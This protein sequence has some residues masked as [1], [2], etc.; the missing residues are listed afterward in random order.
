MALLLW[1]TG[2]GEPQLSFNLA[3]HAGTLLA[4]IIY[5]R[6]T[7]LRLLAAA[8][9]MVVERKVG[10]DRDRV[11]VSYL[12]VATL[13]AL[14]L[15]AFAGESA[16]MMD[17]MPLLIILVMLFFSFVL[18]WVD[19]S[20]RLEL[21]AVDLGWRGSLVTGIF[22]VFAMVPG[23]SR[24]GAT[25]SAGLL[26]G[27]KREEAV[28]FAFLLSIPTIGAAFAYSCLKMAEEGVPAGMLSPMLIGTATSFITGLFAIGFLLRWVR[29][30]DFTPFIIYRIALASALLVVYFA[31]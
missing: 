22:Q 24:S 11:M 19:R 27:L 31:R 9:R 30:K 26:Q 4:V 16:D 21:D 23:V 3:L 13:P 20:A 29:T 17:S 10:D 8:W 14:L 1:L 5:F 28:E 2:W 25:I 18:W 15:G 6:R 12:F 7:V